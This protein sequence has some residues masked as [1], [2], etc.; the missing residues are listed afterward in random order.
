[1]YLSTA[2][3]KENNLRDFLSGRDDDSSSPLMTPTIC[4]LTR[5]LATVA[6]GVYKAGEAISENFTSASTKLMS[7]V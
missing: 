1:M 5:S 2:Y 7:L 6:F 3:K 4:L